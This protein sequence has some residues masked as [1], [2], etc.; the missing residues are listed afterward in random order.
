MRRRDH[1]ITSYDEIP[2]LVDTAYVANLL[3]LNI[4]AVQKYCATGK[5]KATRCGRT[6]RIPKS[7]V[8]RLCEGGAEL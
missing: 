1:Y 4:Q 3:R 2:L 7:E 6:Y 5:I 8:I